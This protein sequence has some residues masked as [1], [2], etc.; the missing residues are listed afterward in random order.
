[1]G[2][3]VVLHSGQS[4]RCPDCRTTSTELLKINLFMDFPLC[5]ICQELEVNCVFASCQHAKTCDRCALQI[6]AGVSVESLEA[7]ANA[8]DLPMKAKRPSRSLLDDHEE[9]MFAIGIDD[10]DAELAWARTLTTDIVTCI[11]HDRIVAV[12]VHHLILGRQRHRHLVQDCRGGLITIFVKLEKKTECGTKKTEELTRKEKVVPEQQT[13]RIHNSVAVNTR[14]VPKSRFN[15][16]KRVHKSIDATKARKEKQEQQLHAVD[17]NITS[18]RPKHK[19]T[20]K[21]IATNQSLRA[22]STRD[23]DSAIRVLPELEVPGASAQESLTL[24]HEQWHLE[25]NPLNIKGMTGIGITSSYE[26]LAIPE[27]VCFLQNS[28]T[29]KR[30]HFA[31]ASKACQFLRVG[32]RAFAKH[33][34]GANQEPLNGWH[35]EMKSPSVK[36]TQGL[37]RIYKRKTIRKSRTRARDEKNR[38]KDANSV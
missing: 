7:D 33:I 8:N 6:G 18:G 17:G 19:E 26:L 12:G 16:K 20:T 35:V 14:K 34:Q 23:I 13:L 36:A 25:N 30:L 2:V 5:S 4:F 1:M 29:K 27:R 9:T 15:R 11:E 24:A 31:S 21:S 38:K 32:K 3:T 22:S 37:Q 10:E 28:R